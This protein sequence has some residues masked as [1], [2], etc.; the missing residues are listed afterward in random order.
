MNF[1]TVI[2]S[3]LCFII[4]LSVLITIHELG[5]LLTAK[6]FNVYAYEFSIGFGK[7]IVRY[8]RPN[9][10]T[11][12][13]IGIVPLGGYVSLYGDDDEDRKERLEQILNDPATSET[14]KLNP[15]EKEMLEKDIPISR[16]LEGIK[17]W[18]KI[19][20]M[21]SGVI[22]NFI[23]GYIIFFIQ[24][25]AFPYNVYLQTASVQDTSISTQFSTQLSELYENI[26]DSKFYI[27]QG[28]YVFDKNYNDQ[29]GVVSVALST[30]VHINA[31]L[32]TYA[33]FAPN[34]I[35]INDLSLDS[36]FTNAIKDGR[37]QTVYR[38]YLYKTW[39]EER[40]LI[41]DGQSVTGEFHFYDKDVSYYAETTYEPIE[42]VDVKFN[43]V[44]A[45]YVYDEDKYVTDYTVDKDEEGKSIVSSI[46]GVLTAQEN[47]KLSS[48]NLSSVKDYSRYLG[49]KAF[50]YAGK[51]WADSTGTIFESIGKLFIGQGWDQ[52]GGIIMIF[53]QSTVVLDTLPFSYYVQL[54]GII[55]VNLGIIN[56]LPFPGLD[57]WH[58]LVTLVEMIFKKRISKKVKNV[59]GT[60]GMILLFT[61]MG[62]L[63]IV[64]IV[65]LATTGVM[66]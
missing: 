60:V 47:G 21:S 24:M 35:K 40:T 13:E 55:S 33:L 31:G 1:G 3:I 62:T 19:I 39:T 45:S 2:L 61:L 12:F 16:S 6:I 50:G 23:L 52:A 59:V 51:M 41:I 34:P 53:A 11:F 15:V 42:T 5:H 27:F 58:I 54:W 44:R 37:G 20:I 66:L 10:E 32:D 18:K 43:L 14:Y 28:T 7:K 48:T 64:D 29:G 63:I 57:G 49:Y 46:S 4:G 30:E 65:R 26:D 17:K 56:L 38:Y 36:S 8:R 9:H 25:V 22:M